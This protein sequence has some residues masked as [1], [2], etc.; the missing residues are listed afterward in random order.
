VYNEWLNKPL[1]YYESTLT[2]RYTSRASYRVEDRMY[3]WVTRS[4]LRL[5]HSHL[6]GFVRRSS[7]NQ[8]DV[9]LRPTQKDIAKSSHSTLATW[10]WIGSQA[11]D[12]FFT[13]RQNSSRRKWLFCYRDLK[14]RILKW[15]S[16]TYI[17]SLCSF[18]VALQRA[19]FLVFQLSFS[20]V[21]VNVNC[22]IFRRCMEQLSM[23]FELGVI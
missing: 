2:S 17:C 13:H 23:D 7:T 19:H 3:K 10:R 11:R 21:P 22:T 14:F 20:L 9:P 6:Y 18:N 12:S 16:H 15:I 5:I 8:F 4:A 1:R